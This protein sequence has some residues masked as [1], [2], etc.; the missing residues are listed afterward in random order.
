MM[1]PAP[2]VTSENTMSVPIAV[3]G[4]TAPAARNTGRMVR[5][6]EAAARNG[7][8]KAS[9]R[10]ARLLLCSC[11]GGPSSGPRRSL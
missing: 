1:L 4:P 3:A 7:T 9:S 11:R 8:T 6:G 10:A 5:S 2:R